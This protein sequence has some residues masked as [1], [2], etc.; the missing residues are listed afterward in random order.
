MHCLFFC[1]S[2]LSDGRP[3]GRKSF[4]ENAASTMIAHPRAE[5]VRQST[6]H[7]VVDWSKVFLAFQFA[8]HNEPS[9]LAVLRSVMLA[10]RLNVTR[11]G[12]CIT[13]IFCLLSFVYFLSC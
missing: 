3:R 8:P 2:S 10:M 1:L 12:T 7:L 11:E 4:D 5:H 13:G 9:N 6:V